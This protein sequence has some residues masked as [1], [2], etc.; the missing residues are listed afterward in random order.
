M[1]NNENIISYSETISAV[2]GVFRSLPYVQNLTSAALLG[3]AV[4]KLPPNLMESLGMHTVKNKWSRRTLLEFN[5]WVQEKAEAH[6]RMKVTSTKQR[7]TKFLMQLQK[8]KLLQRCLLPHLKQMHRPLDM[9]LSPQNL[10]A[11]STV[12]SYTYCSVALCFVGKHQRE[13][14]LSLITTFA[15]CA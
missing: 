15:F 5:D 6:E 3:Q 2:V 1:H 9:A 7:W 12:K 11:V 14:K 8:W 4:Q 10:S 13:K